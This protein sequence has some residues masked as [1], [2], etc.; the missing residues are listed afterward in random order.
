MARVQSEL[1]PKSHSSS[2]LSPSYVISDAIVSGRI[3]NIT[4]CT[5][6]SSFLSLKQNGLSWMITFFETCSNYIILV[7]TR[8]IMRESSLYFWSSSL[9]SAKQGSFSNLI[10]SSTSKNV[11]WTVF[12][13]NFFF[14]K[15]RSSNFAL[16]VVY[17]YYQS[18]SD[19]ATA[20]NLG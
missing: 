7:W 20:G 19:S 18:S 3:L 2:T 12:S 13:L 6:S 11:R 1:V 9:L 10:S 16:S 4:S 17:S 15:L 14:S 8:E 5:S